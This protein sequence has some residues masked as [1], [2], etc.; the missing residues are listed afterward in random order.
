MVHDNEL[1][2]RVQ[3]GDKEAFETLI[4]RYMTRAIA[5]ACK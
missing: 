1:M 2:L 5:F 3:N 4:K